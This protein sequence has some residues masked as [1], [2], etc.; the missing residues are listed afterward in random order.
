MITVVA[1]VLFATEIAFGSDPT[2]KVHV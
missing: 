2:C 1:R